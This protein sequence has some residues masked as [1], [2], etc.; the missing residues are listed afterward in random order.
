MDNKKIQAIAF[1]L[2]AFILPFALFFYTHPSSLGFA[3]AG[4][5]ALV[6]KIASV[7]HGP[8]TPSYV[9]L[10]WLWC[11]LISPFIHS[12]FLKIDLF[13]ILSMSV[14]CMLM[15][16]TVENILKR[17]YPAQP[18][19]TGQFLALSASLIF[20]T[21]FTS[22]Y[23][24][25]NVEVYAFH[26]FTFSLLVYGLVR[27]NQ[28]HK[29]PD[30]II[31][32][33]G[34][35]LGLANHHLTTIFFFPFIFLFTG[36]DIFKIRTTGKDPKKKK[37]EQL[38]REPGIFDFFRTRDFWVFTGVT[39]AITIFFYGIMMYR[40]TVSL[41]FKFGSPDNWDRFYYHISGGAWTKNLQKEVSGI[42]GMRIPYFSWLI[43]HEYGGFLVFFA[44][45]LFELYR[46][47][48][49]R[50]AI[51]A[52]V[53][54]SFLLIYQLRFDQVGD[55]DAYIL[56]PLYF[57]T[58]CIP[59]GL[60]W[61]LQYGKPWLAVIPVLLVAQLLWNFPLADK[62]EF[63]LSESL[64]KTLDESAPKNSVIVVSD[65][66]LVSEYYYY[67][68][69]ENFRPDLV[70][71]NYDYKFTNYT[72]LENLYPDFYKL[73]K[74]E[75]DNFVAQLGAAHPQE[76]YNT[77]CTLDEPRLSD[78]Y[79]RLFNKIQSVCTEH[80]YAL[81]FDPKAF[82]YCID[83]KLCTPDAYVSGCFVSKTKTNMGDSFIRLPY[84]WLNLPITVREP[85]AGDKLVD[86]QAMLDFHTR[87]YTAVGDTARYKIADASHAK[88]IGLEA[89]LKENIPFMFLVD[90]K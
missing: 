72:I 15:F 70:V 69:A 31:A 88:I 90:G 84:K 24:A 67:R 48:W 21:G 50:F 77:G 44:I 16:L 25:T 56:L 52:L 39:A 20:A 63:D 82:I 43:A 81:L 42:V 36:P 10:G 41:P 89:K 86:I 73:I 19:L 27:Y 79:R 12:H 60:E 33:T 87:Y 65:W 22:W 32:A 13:S 78:A 2:L 62:R 45:G 83:N 8:G 3:D 37:K 57:L 23:W 47:K 80:S 58:L 4:E 5:F 34:L 49:F 85:S 7:A 28:S 46:K 30:G 75:Y 18:V 71:L 38:K 66:T 59:F 17:S 53:Y 68:I 1:A 55:S 9:Y 76:I 51:I 26:V 14:A 61:L 35:A 54:A 40:A 29:T 11:Q 6:T 64:M 74:P